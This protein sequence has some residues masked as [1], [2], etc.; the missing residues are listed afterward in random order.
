MVTAGHKR[1]Q[2]DLVH[3]V[4]DWRNNP[5]QPHFIAALPHRLRLSK[6]LL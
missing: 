5:F 4:T 1:G 6:G 3:D 2:Q